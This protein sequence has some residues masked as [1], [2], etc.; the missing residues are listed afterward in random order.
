MINPARAGEEFLGG[1]L[2]G[3]VL[4]GAQTLAG[5][6]AQQAAYVQLGQ[7]YTA[8]A[9]K[10]QQALAIGLA[11]NARGTDAYIAAQR[12]VE[13]VEKTGKAPS[14]AAIGRM[15]AA[16]TKTPPPMWQRWPYASGGGCASLPALP[17]RRQRTA[18]STAS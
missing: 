1:A 4:G 10:V 11:E 6:M 13:Q 18:G 2:V 8:D 17:G 12:M 14:A 16:Q 5:K 3:G 9:E 15:L 7:E